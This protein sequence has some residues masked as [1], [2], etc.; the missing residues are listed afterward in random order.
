[1]NPTTKKQH[2][3][4]TCDNNKK[5]GKP[6]TFPLPVYSPP[7]RY[8]ILKL[9]NKREREKRNICESWKKRRAGYDKRLFDPRTFVTKTFFPP[10]ASW[11]EQMGLD[12]SGG[13]RMDEVGRA[14]RTGGG[15]ETGNVDLTPGVAS[16][17]TR[18]MPP[19]FRSQMT[20]LRK[21]SPWLGYTKDQGRPSILNQI[22]EVIVP[23][24]HLNFSPP[25][26][27]NRFIG[28][29]HSSCEIC[30]SLL[31]VMRM[32]NKRERKQIIIY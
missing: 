1:M 15:G 29:L 32:C 9:T 16:G 20:S 6:L 18:F 21:Y 7:N 19:S 22:M 10:S 28:R 31:I 26:W 17:V 4:P 24:S 13:L 27:G 25:P 23:W 14:K 5:P 8:K 2:P 11:K 30:D 12:R 3:N